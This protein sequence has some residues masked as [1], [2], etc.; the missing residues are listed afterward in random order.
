MISL[1]KISSLLIMVLK[2]YMYFFPSNYIFKGGILNP[3]CRFRIPFVFLKKNSLGRSQAKLMRIADV[4]KS[5]S[6]LL[7][8]E[9]FLKGK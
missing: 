1:I 7:I 3:G 5:L 9:I 2:L 6:I 8:V 4:L